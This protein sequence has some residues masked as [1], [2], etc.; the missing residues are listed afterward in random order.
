MEDLL[1][2][3][4]RSYYNQDGVVVTYGQTHIAQWTRTKSPEI[5]SHVY[6]QLIF[7]KDAKAVQWGKGQSSTHGAATTEQ[8]PAREE[9]GPLP[10][11][12]H[13]I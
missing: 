13:S 2:N 9:G 5:N 12:T 6:G 8:P 3:L 1:Q 7:H 4:L 10:H 11:I